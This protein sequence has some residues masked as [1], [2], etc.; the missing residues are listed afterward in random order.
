M[1]VA[2]SRCIGVGNS[3][4]RG[5]A[6]CSVMPDTFARLA[7]PALAIAR[8]NESANRSMSSLRAALG[9]RHQQ[10]VLALGIVSPSGMP[11]AMPSAAQRSRTS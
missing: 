4:V 10:A 1:V 5:G 8:P 7:A 3:A 11:A 6:T 2:R 9:D